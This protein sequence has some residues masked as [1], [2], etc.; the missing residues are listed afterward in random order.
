[1]GKLYKIQV[2]KTCTVVYFLFPVQCV[3]VLMSSHSR[4]HLACDA[5]FIVGTIINSIT[6]EPNARLRDERKKNKE[7]RERKKKESRQQSEISQ[8]DDIRKKST[9]PQARDSFCV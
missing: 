7:K 8:L 3:L 5:R 6:D 9:S 4:K 1:M 2:W